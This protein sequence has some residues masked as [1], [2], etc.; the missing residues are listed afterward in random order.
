MIKLNDIFFTFQGEGF[1]A[2]RRSLFIRM[3][4]CNLRC[5][6]CDTEF[7]TSLDYTP[8]LI[9]DFL[10]TEPKTKFAVITGGEPMMNRHVPEIIELLKKHDFEIACETNG[11]FPI[12]E[13][14][15]FPTVSPKQGADWFIHPQAFTVAREFKYV[16]D[17][18]FSFDLL[19][20]HN[21]KDGRRYSLSPEF[22][23]RKNQIPRI[24]NYIK[25]NPEWRLNLQLHKYESI[26]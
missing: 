15:H 22:N 3:P 5:T 21:V 16:V 23:D 7:N 14:I 8:Q 2:G 1:H 6:W 24:E 10:L 20:K 4:Y 19:K 11:T 12:Y 9:D 26:K 18:A 17:G 13:G 25:E